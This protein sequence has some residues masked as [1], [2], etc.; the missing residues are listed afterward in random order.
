MRIG[1]ITYD[2]FPPIGGQGVES[3]QLYK[4]L[5]VRPGI[6]VEVISARENHLEGH[7]Q[8]KVVT[9][10]DLGPFHFSL[11]AWRNL[12]RYVAEFNLDLI[13]VYGA[14]GGVFLF[15]KPSVPLIY[16]AN[17]T[18]AQQQRFL[19]KK[20][21]QPLA[22]L[23]KRGFAF[24]DR[25]VS[26]S[27]TT[28]DSIVKDYG[29]SPDNIEVIPVGVD[30]KTF[31]RLGLDRIRDSILCVGRLCPRKGINHLIE[32][33][34]IAKKERPEIKLFLAGEGALRSE[35]EQQVSLS[36]LESNVVFLGKVSDDELVEW[37]NTVELFV[38]PTLFEGF[39][40]VCLEALSCGTPVITTRVPGVVDI[41]K[42]EPPNQLVPPE[43]PGEMAQAILDYFRKQTTD[44][45]I[46][47]GFEEILLGNFSWDA[48][49]NRF[50]ELYK[51]VLDK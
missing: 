6:D 15:K 14:I 5:T 30:R 20:Y 27:S 9:N 51:N 18:Y 40:I 50:L 37:Y 44:G 47:D 11:W 31:R 12:D 1:L 32:A 17:Q 4:E 34:N 16:L 21:Y 41:I 36:N 3:Y 48:V 28:R 7:K 43:N 8:V 49:C 46:N 39:G 29:L 33:I 19:K 24:A 35:L 10:E 45:P 42:N 23:E 38:L 26:I 22:Y 25:I 2:F 13:Q